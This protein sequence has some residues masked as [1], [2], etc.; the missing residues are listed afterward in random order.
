MDSQ[1]KEEKIEYFFQKEEE[2]GRHEVWLDGPDY[3]LKNENP[4]K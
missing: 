1:R 4:D 2:E 3:T